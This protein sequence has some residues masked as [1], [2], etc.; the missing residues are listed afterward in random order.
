MLKLELPF[1]L[2]QIPHFLRSD[3]VEIVPRKS[4][5]VVLEALSVSVETG[6]NAYQFVSDHRPEPDGMGPFRGML[7]PRS[8]LPLGDGIAIEQQMLFPGKGDAVAFSWRLLGRPTFPARLTAAPIFSATRPFGAAGFEIEAETNGGRLA[9]RPY[10]RSSKIIADTNGRLVATPGVIPGSFEFELSPHP[11]V[12]IFSS[13][14]RSESGLDP[15]I[16]GF[17]AQLTVQRGR[18]ADHDEPRQLIA[19]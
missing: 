19:A 11:S 4:L 12:L 6:H 17:L 13:E 5:E 10:D 9:W 16:G 2:S 1:H 3:L 14:P 7:W 8:L 18:T 15:L